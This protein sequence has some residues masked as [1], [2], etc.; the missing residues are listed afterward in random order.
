MHKPPV[1]DEQRVDKIDGWERDADSCCWRQGD[2]V[3]TGDLARACERNAHLQHQQNLGR[4]L[5]AAREALLAMP[6]HQ[7]RRA[8]FEYL[9]VAFQLDK[10]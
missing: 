2:E 5:R 9:R 7:E 6:S 8:A 3:A 10:E 4:R 1:L